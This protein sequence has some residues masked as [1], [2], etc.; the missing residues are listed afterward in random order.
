MIT[1][2]SDSVKQDIIRGIKSKFNT[3]VD[4]DIIDF[5]QDFQSKCAVE[6]GFIKK[7]AVRFYNL[8]AFQYDNKHI[9]GRN[10]MKRLL[11]KHNGDRKLA[12]AEFKELNRAFAISNKEKKD[13]AKVAKVVK[14]KRHDIIRS[15]NTMFTAR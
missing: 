4:T 2:I 11:A 15:T 10:I 8:A 13:K 3:D 6:H 14:P 9:D 1:K 5:L 12:R 7:K